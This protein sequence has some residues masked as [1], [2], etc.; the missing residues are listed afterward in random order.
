LVLIVL[1]AETIAQRRRDFQKILNREKQPIF[2]VQHSVDTDCRYSRNTLHIATSRGLLSVD[3]E[4]V[5][6]ISLNE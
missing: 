5:R 2:A 4:C 1:M 3:T 6:W